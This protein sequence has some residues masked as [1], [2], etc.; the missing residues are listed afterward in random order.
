MDTQYMGMT[1]V[2]REYIFGSTAIAHWFDDYP[3]T[4]KDIDY[5]ADTPFLLDIPKTSGEE[6]HVVPT[7]LFDKLELLNNGEKTYLS[8]DLLYTIKVSHLHWRGNNGKWWKHLKDVVFLQQKGCVIVD[9]VYDDFYKL[10]CEKFG[11]KSNIS[12]KKATEN[13]FNDGVERERNH[14]WMHQYFKVDEKPAY[15][16]ALQSE[17]SPMMSQYKFSMLPEYHQSLCALEEMFVVSAERKI[18]LPNA[19]MKLITSMTKGWFPRYMIVN[20][21]N[22]LDGFVKEKEIFKKKYKDLYK[23][24]IDK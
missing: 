3:N 5:I 19:Y 1:F 11:D 14:D 16:Y 15:M 7:K 4:P 12:L 24:T 22:L 13:F 20:A 10:W 17:D 2:I 18:S 21:E 6:H 8:P 9:D 23:Y